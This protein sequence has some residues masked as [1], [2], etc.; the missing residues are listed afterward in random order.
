MSQV[1]AGDK[2]RIYYTGKTADGR[3]FDAVNEGEPFEMT[4]GAGEFW[5]L[6][7]DSL[8]GMRAGESKDVQIPQK[9]AIPYMEDLVFVVKRSELPAD[10]PYEE[11]IMIHL[12]QPDGRQIPV[13]VQKITN[14]DVTLNANHPLAGLELL[15]SFT[16][17]SIE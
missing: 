5:P 8:I 11:G 4:I 16:L 13:T 7:E 2:V 1:K 6:V 9:D 17:V 12:A 15:I 3:I 10:F 14:E